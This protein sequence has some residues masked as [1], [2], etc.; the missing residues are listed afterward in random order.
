MNTFKFIGKISN[1]NKKEN[2]VKI[3]SN[4]KK[5]LKFLIKQ[6]ENNMAYPQMYGDNL[7]N[8]C[9]PVFLKNGK[10]RQLIDFES[11]FDKN[12][13]S[14]VSYASK[15]VINDGFSEVEYIWKDDFIDNVYTLVNGLPT[16]TIY[17]VDGEFNI[18]YYKN[19]AYNN[20]NIKSIKVNNSARPEFTLTLELFYNNSSLDESNK[21]NKFTLNAYIEQYVYANKRKEYFPIQV[22]F[23]TNQ[24]DFKNAAHIDIIKHRK[25][26]LNPT[27]EEGYVK[28]IWEA[29]YIRGAQLI[30]PP[31]ETLPKEVQFEIKNAGRDLKEYMSNVVGEAAEFIC[32]TRPD[33]TL[34]KDGKVYISLDCTENEFKS[35]IHDNL[36]AN[37]K[38]EK[39][40]DKIANEDAQENPFN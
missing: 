36:G 17:E 6:N 18:T 26:N 2:I 37:I 15:Y 5:Q 9:V 25:S 21:K 23:I 20:F 29:Q 1:P 8:G 16:N 3:T 24:Y 35:K 31:L 7:F 28:A 39:T 22:Q 34:N 32:L 19:K 12:I 38:Q 27:K 4:G 30:L 33:N 14:Q 40:L 11:R 10:G 13:L